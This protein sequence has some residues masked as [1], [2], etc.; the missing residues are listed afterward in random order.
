MAVHTESAECRRQLCCSSALNLQV[1][2]SAQAQQSCIN[3]PKISTAMASQA[4]PACPAAGKYE[5]GHCCCGTHLCS[6]PLQHLPCVQLH[7]Q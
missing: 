6:R 2:M 4:C 3:T 1:T 5:K 7:H